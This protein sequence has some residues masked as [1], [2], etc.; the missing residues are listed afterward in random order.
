NNSHYIECYGTKNFPVQVADENIFGKTLRCY[1]VKGKESVKIRII[2]LGNG[3]IWIED[4]NQTFVS[5]SYLDKLPKFLL[6]NCT[7]IENEKKFF[8]SHW[9]EDDKIYIKNEKARK[10][11]IDLNS[12]EIHSNEHEK[13]LIPFIKNGFDQ[14]NIFYSIFSQFE[15]E[16]YIL[17]LKDR[18]QDSEPVIIYLPR[19]NL[20]FKLEGRKIISE[21]FKD[22]RLSL[23]Q[24]I[25]TLLGVP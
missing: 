23:N 19:L 1:E 13:F 4:N 7:H 17:A 22:Y 24:H 9:Y 6:E 20:K 15:D 12:N 18:E 2:S 25:N 14:S 5:R 8:Y 16:N 3:I 11:T 10:F 21:N